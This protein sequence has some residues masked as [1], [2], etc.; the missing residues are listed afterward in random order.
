MVETTF[1]VLLVV[2]FDDP[3]SDCEGVGPLS[4]LVMTLRILG[5]RAAS[6]FEKRQHKFTA[7]PTY[8]ALTLCRN[9]DFVNFLI[10]VL[11][12]RCATRK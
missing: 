1:G 9:V 8:V 10:A 7:R 12:Q 6:T 11:P 5:G 4:F 2:L 3:H